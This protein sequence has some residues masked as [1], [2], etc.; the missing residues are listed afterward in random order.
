MALAKFGQEF[1]CAEENGHSFAI[2]S[3]FVPQLP[4]SGRSPEDTC[5]TYIH[6]KMTII[7][8]R[9]LTIGSANATN[10]SM[11][12]DSEL[13]LAWH[14]EHEHDAIARG[15]RALRV[16]LLAEHTRLSPSESLEHLAEI[17]GLVE[18]MRALTKREPP[19]LRE[20]TFAAPAEQG[21]LDELMVSLGD[22]E[23]AAIAEGLFE[24]ITDNPRGIVARVVTAL[25]E[26]AAR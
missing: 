24:E 6:S 15:I 20:V 22:P 8:D 5:P 26:V 18:R 3:P 1:T 4:G 13:N 11:G 16:S 25:H 7:D 23:R 9:F 21:P 10:R 17:E 19:A 14:T 12:L 2:F